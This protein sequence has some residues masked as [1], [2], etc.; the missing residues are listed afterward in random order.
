[1]KNLMITATRHNEGKTAI[2]L[3]L[4]LELQKRIGNIGFMKPLGKRS[5]ESGG[6]RIDE[7]AA[8]IAQVCNLRENMQNMSPVTLDPGFPKGSV[9][10]KAKADN[11]TNVKD[12]FREL[13]QRHEFIMLEGT[14][15]AAVGEVYG[16][17]NA[18]LAAQLNAGVLLISSGGIAQ[19][20]DEILLN[21]A[22]FDRHGVD[23][24]G[25][26]INKVFPHE[27]KDLE[28]YTAKILAANGIPVLGFV[29][30]SP[31]LHKPTVYQVLE[32]LQG[33]LLHGDRAALDLHCHRI[34]IG[35]MM[36]R[37][38]LANAEEGMLLVVPGDREDLI[39][40]FV[41]AAQHDPNLKP[42]AIVICGGLRP[43]PM[44]LDILK[45]S[46]IPAMAV[47]QDSY[48]TASRIH[49]MDVKISPKDKH[50]I[51]L[52]HSMAAANI[53]IDAV[54][55]ALRGDAKKAPAKK[56]AKPH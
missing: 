47:K 5:F 54:L 2:T 56:S 24:I 31:E 36:P 22:Y 18:S 23:L 38:A 6:L 10:P 42:R 52:I 51:D 44:T 41:A 27:L 53:D 12:S 26:V 43:S 49:G 30:Y 48:S 16:L 32:G 14:G 9:S 33:E 46:G 13:S 29:P 45:R 4:T 15:H 40:A 8:L 11:L 7:D 1:M 28:R 37:N 50:K 34:A 17:S 20:V 35:A 21:K 39:L 55:E 19:P 3:G 25:V